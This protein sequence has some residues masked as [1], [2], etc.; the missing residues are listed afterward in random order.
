[1]NT[2]MFWIKANLGVLLAFLFLLPAGIIDLKTKTVPHAL[3]LTGLLGAVVFTAFSL[4]GGRCTIPEI[5]VSLVP[6]SLLIVVSFLTH[7]NVGLGDGLSFLIVGMFSGLEITSL[8]L[9]GGL[10]MAA[11]TGAFL[12]LC[13]KAGRNTCLPFLPFSL[14]A[15]GEILYGLFQSNVLV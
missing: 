1:M 12:M 2:M 11:I 14:A 4:S 3:I 9:F 13:R 10:V 5:L 7:G 8:I 15:C 6:G